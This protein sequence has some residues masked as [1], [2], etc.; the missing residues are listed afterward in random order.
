MRAGLVRRK[1][2]GRSSAELLTRWTTGTRLRRRGDRLIG[3]SLLWLPGEGL[4]REPTK[5]LWRRS[6]KGLIGRAATKTLLWWSRKGLI[7]RGATRTL[8]WRSRKG[9]TGRVTTKA[10]LWRSREGLRCR[11][12]AEVGLRGTKERLGRPGEGCRAAGLLLRSRKLLP[13]AK[14]LLWWSREQLAC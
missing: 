4:I 6:R 13:W 5:T 2:R 8:L 12:M 11:P 1:A 3:R 14:D 9:M 7:G 10:M